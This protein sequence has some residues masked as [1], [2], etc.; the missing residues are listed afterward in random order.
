M[1]P[2]EPSED[3][4]K[5]VLM[6][7]ARSGH[8]DIAHGFMK[9]SNITVQVELLEQF[10][11]MYQIVQALQKKDLGPAIQWTLSK[12]KELLARGSNLEF[13]LHK[14]Q[15]VR[16][17]TKTNEPSAALAY[18]RQ[19]LSVFGDRYFSGKPSYSFVMRSY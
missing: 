6:H 10:S 9:E 12:R 19:N 11:V 15:F 17:L 8:F 7:F 3:L 18:A 1:F 16:I 13:V 5:A 14:V 2:I 4:N